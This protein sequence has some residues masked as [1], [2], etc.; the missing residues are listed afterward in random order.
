MADMNKK[1]NITLIGMPGCGKSTI[2]VLLAKAINYGFV[3]SDLL[4]QQEQNMKLQ[5]IID[6]YGIEAFNRIE[7]DVNSRIE[8]KRHIIA[9]G[10]SVIYGEDAMR[11]LSEISKIIY[12]S[13]SCDEIV[14]RLNNIKTR[15][16]SMNKG[17]TIED[18][19]NRR[20]PL[21]EKYADY[22]VNCDGMDIEA[23][24]EAIM[25]LI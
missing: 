8:L 6:K 4:I 20:V 24:V 13:L 15:G 1:S 14:R 12:I 21:Y 23:S 3:D 5:E 22:V 25:N 9:T 2:G 7:N 11:H 16:I 18:L 10:G 17:E 19:Y